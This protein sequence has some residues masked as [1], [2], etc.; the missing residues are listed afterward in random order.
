MWIAALLAAS[1]AVDLVVGQVRKLAESASPLGNALPIMPVNDTLYF[2]EVLHDGNPREVPLAQS[3]K[4]TR[5]LRQTREP[6]PT[7]SSSH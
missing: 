5:Q 2:Q 6:K 3:A 1:Q 7:V 4:G